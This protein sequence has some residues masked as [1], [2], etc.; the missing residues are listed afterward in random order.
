MP[1]G[2]S[3]RIKLTRKYLNFERTSRSHVVFTLESIL[4]DPNLTTGTIE[5]AY[6][7]TEEGAERLVKNALDPP[8]TCQEENNAPAQEA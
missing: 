8:Q 2:R 4:V 7:V 6:L 5:N 1:S 3:L